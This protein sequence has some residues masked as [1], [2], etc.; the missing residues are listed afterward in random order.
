[1][2]EL[3][4]LLNVEDVRRSIAF[5]Q[6]V[7]GAK[8]E[9]EWEHEGR[10]RWARI[11]AEG[12]KLM[13]NSP[14]AAGSATRRDRPEFADIVFYLMC[15]DAPALRAKL[16]AAGLAPTELHREEYGNVEFGLRDPDGYALRFSSRADGPS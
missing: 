6:T 15:D 1:M 14:D 7:L 8:V 3:I 4:P 13:L 2:S 9:S 10:V 12:G 5:Y 16:V 11:A